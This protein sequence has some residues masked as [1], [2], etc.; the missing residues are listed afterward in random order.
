MVRWPALFLCVAGAAFA[1][2]PLI[3][4][5][6]RY[7]NFVAAP[8]GAAPPA[9]T[10]ALT[11][12]T[13]GRMPWTAT[14]ST[15]RGGAWLGVT[16]GQGLLPGID[17]FESAALVISVSPAGLPTGA[18]YG[19]VTVRAQGDAQSAPADNSP[20]ILEVALTVGSGT[21]APGLGV[22][23]DTLAFEGV[24]GSGR[25][26]AANVQI[27]NTGGG[28]LSWTAAAEGSWLGLTVASGSLL[29]VS[30][31]AGALPAGV[32][33]GRVIIT[34]P[35]AVNSPVSI[36]AALR[37]RD[38]AAPAI[39]VNAPSL[40]LSTPEEG[41]SPPPQA[42][43]ISN[44]GEGV[45]RWRLEVLTFN[46]GAW[47]S[48]SPTSGTGT[49]TVVV[50]GDA[51]G[52]GT[53]SYAGRVTIVAEGAANSPLP[54]PVTLA[55]RR[56]QPELESRGVVN[57][58]TLGPGFLAPGELVTLFGA[59]LGPREGMVG[60]PDPV[61][62]GTR[63]YL[64]GFTAPLLYV[65]FGQINLQVPYELAGRSVTRMAVTIDGLDPV[66]MQLPLREAAPGIFAALNQNSTLNTPQNPADRGSVIQLYLT[67]QGLF[68]PPLPTGAAAPLE[69]PFPVPV[70]PVRVTM[71]GLEA[72]V[73]F[74]GAAPGFVGLTQVNVTVPTELRPSAQVNVALLVGSHPAGKR[75]ALAV[76]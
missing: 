20:Q 4:L 49:G 44:A 43:E 34:A 46:G 5:S 18:Y 56:A 60:A 75:V 69:P 50:S 32:Y 37:L 73:L 26:G 1:H 70:L 58:A 40:L 9:Q 71:D 64:D 35:G 63:V 22:S 14:A 16:P 13:H 6:K 24:T 72:P 7:L 67:G 52:L 53:G 59:R 30:A 21:A 47:L 28:T 74:A 76:K 39:R 3:G 62:A 48:V 15:T 41:R 54:V 68:D 61:L 23:P 11:N 25:V 31:Q 42:L 17:P 51:R 27:S 36:P 55:I 12:T 33:N 19:M 2:A 57:A 8:G 65:S 45:L 66:E 29:S 38:P 10:V